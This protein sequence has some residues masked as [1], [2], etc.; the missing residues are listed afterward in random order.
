MCDRE[1]PPD[2]QLPIGLKLVA[3]RKRRWKRGE[4]VYIEV[5]RLHP[6]AIGDRWATLVPDSELPDVAQRLLDQVQEDLATM[7]VLAFREKYAHRMK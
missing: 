1:V 7:P 6:W 4:R 3:R 5:R 2:L